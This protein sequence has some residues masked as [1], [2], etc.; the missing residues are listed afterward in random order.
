MELDEITLVESGRIKRKRQSSKAHTTPKFRD[1]AEK[2][3]AAKET[4]HSGNQ[5]EE[6]H[7]MKIKK[8]IFFRKGETD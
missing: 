3:R 1:Q 6:C 7:V 4:E 5:K 8:L 2:V